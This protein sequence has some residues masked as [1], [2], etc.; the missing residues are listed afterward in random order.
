M[1]KQ[2]FKNRWFIWALAAIIITSFS[3]WGFI[4][5]S[6]IKMFNEI[7]DG[8]ILHRSS[9]SMQNQIDTSNWQT[10]RNEE[11]GFEVKYP[12]GWEIKTDSLTNKIS[13]N[14]GNPIMSPT[15]SIQFTSKKYSEILGEE[16]ETFNK[17]QEDNIG[18]EQPTGQS[19]NIIFAKNPAKEFI[20]FSPVGFIQQ[21]IVVSKNNQAIII[22]SY[23]NTDLDQILSTFK[24]IK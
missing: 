15:L 6:N 9:P 16:Q 5:Y 4:E 24:F 1:T 13:I 17:Y 19:Q 23:L 21:I 7:A 20:Y 3:V 2:I 10:Y 11:Y 14:R 22:E 8:E 18:L 12:N